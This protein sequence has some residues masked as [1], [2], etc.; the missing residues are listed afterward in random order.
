MAVFQNGQI[1]K[2]PILKKILWKFHGLV[3][4][5]VELIDAKGIDHSGWEGENKWAQY[6]RNFKLG[7]EVLW[8][9]LNWWEWIPDSPN[10]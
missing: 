7:L 8:I 3:P 4:G 9:L 6:S 1:S 5:L 10:F 2:S